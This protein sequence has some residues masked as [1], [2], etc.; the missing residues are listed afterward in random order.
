MLYAI[1]AEDVEG[2]LE[3]R[4]ETRPAHLARLE[5]LKEEGR[6]VL[7]G[8]HPA[9]DSENPGP[10]GFTGSLIVAEFESLDAAESWALADPYQA[11]G[12]YAKVVVKPFKQVFPV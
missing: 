8:P 6:M 7:A 12:V 3:R 4:L 5:Q 2:S 11:A 1:I 9:I 10:V